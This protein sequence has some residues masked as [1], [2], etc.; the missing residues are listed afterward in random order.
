MGKRLAEE[1]LAA[2]METNGRYPKKV[3]FTL[4]SSDFISSEGATI[5]QIFY[6][7]GVEPMRDGFGQIRSLR[8]I[9]SEQLGRPRVD[10]VVQTS[11]QLRDIAASRLELIN[12]AIAM[13]AE[14]R[15]DAHENFVRKG[16]EDAER[17]LLAKGFSPGRRPPLCR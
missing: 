3:S 6:L 11:G 13:A 5:A 15:D 10:V 9:P 16:F 17:L 2:E 1:L 8:L 14:A 12:R 7:L 4:W